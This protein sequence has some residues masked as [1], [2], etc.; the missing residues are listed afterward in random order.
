MTPLTRRRFIVRAV[1][2]AAAILPAVH[3]LRSALAALS[4]TPHN[5]PI[6]ALFQ[7][8]ESARRLGAA[9]LNAHPDAD[10][11]LLL[12]RL[13][14]VTRGRLSLGTDGLRRA[15]TEACS[16]DFGAGRVVRV[17]GWVLAESEAQAC[18]LVAIRG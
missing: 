16:E 1:L 12:E 4:L 17:E 6:I 2:G 3:G 11:S 8:R 15:L 18:A 7:H 10:P 13:A 9:Y 14:H 5:D